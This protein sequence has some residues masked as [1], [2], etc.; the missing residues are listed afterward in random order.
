MGTCEVRL[1]AF[2]I[3][4]A[5]PSGGQEVGYGG[6]NENAPHRL[7]VVGFLGVFLFWFGLV[8]WIWFFQDR[9]SLYPLAVLELTL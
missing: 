1:N 6:L 5:Q 3:M 8:F 2:C 9:V 7:I 4:Y